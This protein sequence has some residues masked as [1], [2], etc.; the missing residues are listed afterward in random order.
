MN[1]PFLPD[2]ILVDLDRF[3]LVALKIPFATA[4]FPG[5]V[6]PTQETDSN[7]WAATWL[8]EHDP[9]IPHF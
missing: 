7:L 3:Q 9:Y 5:L 2:Y 4:L 8:W 1:L 6:N